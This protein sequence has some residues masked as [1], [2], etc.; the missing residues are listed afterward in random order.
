MSL[1]PEGTWRGRGVEAELGYTTKDSTEQV[2]VA[3]VFSPDQD[4]DVDGRSLT[5]YGQFSEKTEPFTLKTLRVF[6][7]NTNDLADLSGI[8]TNEVDVVVVHEEDLEGQTRA[9]IRFINPLGSGGVAMKSKMT[10]DQK[11]AFAARMRGRVLASAAAT[12]PSPAAAAAKAAPKNTKPPAAPKHAAGGKP[13]D[14][15]VPF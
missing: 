15:K 6:G 11:A 9:R 14:G 5:W 12:Q 13:E 2:G 10:D 3:V 7:W 1:I 4:Q 8:D